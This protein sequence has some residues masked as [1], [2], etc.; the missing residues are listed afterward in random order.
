M[1]VQKYG[2]KFADG[3]DLLQVEFF[4]IQQGGQWTD[5]KTG[6]LFGNGLFYHYREAQ[7]LLWPS[8]DH[9]R[10]SDLLLDNFLNNTITAVLGPKDAGKTHTAAKYALTD[11]FCF[12]DTTLILVSSTDLRGL[13]LR[14]WG[15]IKKLWGEG[16]E[17]FPWLPG[18]VLEAKHAIAT[19]S[20]ATGTPRDMRKGIICIPCLAAGGQYVGLGKFVGVKQARRRLIGDEA[21]FMRDAYLES[22]ANLNS[23][24]FKGIFLGNPLGQEDPLDKIS[25]PENGWLTHPEPEKTTSWKNRWVNGKTVNLVGIDSPNFDYSQDPK[26]R[27]GYLTNKHSMAA[28]EAFYGKNSA[29]Y[30]EQC[31]GVRKSGLNARRVITREMCVANGAFDSALWQAG[32]RIRIAAADIAYGGIGGDRCVIGHAEFGTSL[33]GLMQ[34]LLFPPVLVPV[35]Y[36]NADRPEDQIAV[37]CRDY[38]KTYSVPPANFGY[39]STGRGTMGVAFARHWEGAGAIIAVEFGGGPTERPVSLDLQ[40]IDER[41]HVKRPKKCSEH[42]CKFVTEL[43]FSVA[44]S[45]E[46]GQ[47]RGLTEEVAK[48]GYSR[49]WKMTRGDRIEIE[50]KEDTKERTGRSP[51]LFDQTAT[52]VEVARQ[53]GFQI[54]KIAKNIEKDET[55]PWWVEAQK[56]QKSILRKATLIHS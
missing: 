26:P 39:D 56:Q 46:G 21:Q 33:D 8:E 52:L 28:V 47:V 38:C 48:E 7:K 17:R 45:I 16:V 27:F 49:E 44:Y 18:T 55:E 14:V 37:F 50:S 11:Y 29:R 22:I 23:G 13:E 35:D 51:D 10:W 25:E 20:M 4:M 53:R 5:K 24:D 34:I 2:L 3:M 36:R 19:D 54:R 43:W 12:P 9:H 42:Y 32:E 15:D 6:R 30:Y 41:T 40:I 31:L 1:P